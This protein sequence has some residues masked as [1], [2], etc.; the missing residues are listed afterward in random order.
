M[1]REFEIGDLVR[2]KSLN[3]EGKV[4]GLFRPGIETTYCVRYVSQ[5]KSLDDWLT[6]GELEKAA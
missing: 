3:K 1:D 5:E 6:G 4:I 2:I